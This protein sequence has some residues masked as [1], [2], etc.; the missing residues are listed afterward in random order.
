[1]PAAPSG[2][3]TFLFTDVEGSTALWDRHP[4]A[5]EDALAEHDRH[6]RAVADAHDGYVFTT[7][8]DSFAIAFPTAIDAV[9]SALEIQHGLSGRVGGL[10]LKVRMGVHSGVATLR[11]S[12]YFGGAV[13]R[14]ARVSAA[15]HGGQ[16]I[17]TEPVAKTV[18]AL[19]PPD[20]ELL[21]LG[22]H[23]LRGLVEPERLH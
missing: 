1:M 18:A 16:M 22:T 20:T 9:W 11:D 3:V 23:R 17:L 12:D 2:H 15:A 5:M 10:E 8:G 7:A 14:A 19:L 13:N 21:D 6:I 4:D